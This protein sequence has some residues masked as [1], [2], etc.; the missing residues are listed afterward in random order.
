MKDRDKELAKALAEF[1]TFII[2]RYDTKHQSARNQ[3]LVKGVFSGASCGSL[4]EY[5][6]EMRELAFEHMSLLEIANIEKRSGDGKN[7]NLENNNEG[8]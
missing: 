6:K 2:D 3:I 1:T 7:A 8:S 5:A 4:V